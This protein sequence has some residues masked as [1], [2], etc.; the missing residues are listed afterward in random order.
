MITKTLTPFLGA[1]PF[2]II[3]GGGEACIFSP[4]PGNP[5]N[6]TIAVVAS[7]NQGGF[8]FAGPVS[9]GATIRFSQQ[10]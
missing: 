2:V 1:K 8:I 9:A 3:I 10:A 4:A 6:E 5:Q 7:V